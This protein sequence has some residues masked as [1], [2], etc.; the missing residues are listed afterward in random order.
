MG[1]NG[2]DRPV[3]QGDAS[4][5]RRARGQEKG[6][7]GMARHAIKLGS[8][9]RDFEFPPATP[10]PVRACN[11]GFGGSLLPPPVRLASFRSGRHRPTAF[12][13]GSR[14]AHAVREEELGHTNRTE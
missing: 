13:G 6:D 4:E 1:E 12:D 7:E 14:G 9:F 11:G 10:S 2:D 5:Y 8:I 3:V